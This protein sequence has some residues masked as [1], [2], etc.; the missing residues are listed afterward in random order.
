M[1][2]EQPSQICGDLQALPKPKPFPFKNETELHLLLQ[3]ITDEEAADLVTENLP[4]ENDQNLAKKN[5]K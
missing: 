3:R 2:T 5:H 4:D 1:D